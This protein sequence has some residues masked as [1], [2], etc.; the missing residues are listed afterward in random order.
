MDVSKSNAYRKN[1]HSTKLHKPA[2]KKGLAA[3]HKYHKTED[4]R[5][6]KLKRVRRKKQATHAPTA[7]ANPNTDVRTGDRVTTTSEMNKPAPVQGKAAAHQSKKPRRRAITPGISGMI[8]KANP[9][10]RPK[11]PLSLVEMTL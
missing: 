6:V 8:K 11:D 10:P 5:V 3:Q 1:P 7:V 4:G 9:A 2:E